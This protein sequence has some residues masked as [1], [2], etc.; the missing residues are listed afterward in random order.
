M[1]EEHKK[2][3]RNHEVLAANDE[4]HAMQAKM[5]GLFRQLEEVVTECSHCG[6][7]PADVEEEGN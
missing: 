2:A 1:R 4:L 3:Q 5:A 6:W 7:N